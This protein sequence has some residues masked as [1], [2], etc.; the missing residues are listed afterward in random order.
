[1]QGAHDGVHV[2]GVVAE[3]LPAYDACKRAVG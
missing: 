1:M 3:R 2:S